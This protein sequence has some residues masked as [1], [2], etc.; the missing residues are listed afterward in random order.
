MSSFADQFRTIVSKEKDPR[1]KRESESDIAYPTGFLAFDFLNGIKVYY[2]KNNDKEYSSYN[3]IGIVDGS[4]VTIIGRSGCG[5]TTFAMQVAGNI[6]KKYDSST[7]FHDDI[8]GGIVLTRKQQL[9]EL[10][11]E[12]FTSRYIS[13]NTGITAEN[14]Y[15]RIKT[16]HDIKN[17]D[18]ASYEYNT[19]E[20][21]SNGNPIIKLE[22]T[23]YILDSLALL[24]PEKYADEEDLSGQMAAT[25][26]A[27]TNS[28]IFKR[29][30]PML[31]NANIILFVINHITEDVQI[32]PFAKKQA[33]L[34][35]L[36][37]GETLGGGRVPVYVTNLLIRLDDHSKLKE[38]EAYGINGIKVTASLVKSRTSNAGSS[39]T[40]IFDYKNG[41]DKELSLFD[42]LKDNKRVGGA[43]AYLYFNCRPDLKFSQKQLKKKLNEDIE[44]R[45][46]FATEANMV[47]QELIYDPGVPE[48]RIKKVYDINDLILGEL[49]A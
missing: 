14:F 6:I 13:R 40:L 47:L 27:K 44:L 22:P 20:V 32:T 7:I 9:L 24:M 8:E 25:A 39:V 3:S 23:I 1:K 30:I 48:D 10:Y 41:F 35:F 43:G 37:P 11:D 34:A 31:K 46:A 4:M 5:K 28:A 16:I 49:A 36:K 45:K 29:I 42:L 38:E 12:E 2:K 19:G 21:D 15:E 18:R 17:N 33:Q 26:A